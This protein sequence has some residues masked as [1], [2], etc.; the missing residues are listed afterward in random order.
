MPKKSKF[1]AQVTSES[2]VCEGSVVCEF[3]GGNEGCEVCEVCEG[4]RLVREVREVW[5][6]R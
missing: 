4:S 5:L 6:V 2:E 1:T 3:S